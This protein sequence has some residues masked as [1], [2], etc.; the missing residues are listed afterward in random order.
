MTPVIQT[1]SPSFKRGGRTV[2]LDEAAEA[3]RMVDWYRAIAM[4]CANT[5]QGLVGRFPR[6][7]RPDR[8]KGRIAELQRSEARAYMQIEWHRCRAERYERFAGVG[9]SSTAIGVPA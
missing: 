1:M 3:R 8:V 9:P 2:A 5:I 7:H 6:G 4:D